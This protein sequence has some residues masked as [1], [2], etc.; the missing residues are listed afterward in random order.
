MDDDQHAELIEHL[1]GPR[2]SV[3]NPERHSL[4]GV[5]RIE[6]QLNQIRLFLMLLVVL[7][8]AGSV[9]VFV[10]SSP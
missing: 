6:W 7:V 9:V 1:T 4:Y 3:R 2:E 10:V 5:E 8:A